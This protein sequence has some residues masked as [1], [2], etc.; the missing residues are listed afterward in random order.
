MEQDN[1]SKSTC[2]PAYSDILKKNIIFYLN[3]IINK[4][5]FLI[6]K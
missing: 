1:L 4:N 3:N 2:Y 5:I 6:N